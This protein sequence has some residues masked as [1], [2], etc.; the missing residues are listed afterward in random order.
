MTDRDYTLIE[1]PVYSRLWP[2]VDSIVRL[3]EHV[4]LLMRS[5]APEL[6]NEAEIDLFAGDTSH[7][8][9][10]IPLLGIHLPPGVGDDF[11]GSEIERRIEEWCNRRSDD[12][13]RSLA[14]V[15]PAPTWKQLLTPGA[16]PHSSSL[17][18]RSP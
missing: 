8:G 13:L 7:S 11:D 3:M 9:G 14:R 12:A 18:K 1:V 16:Y 6:P 15:T 5:L 17:P 4:R 10:P 2:D